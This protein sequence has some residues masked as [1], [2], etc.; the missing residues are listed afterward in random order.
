MLSA[1]EPNPSVDLCIQQQELGSGI[2]ALLIY[3]LTLL[4]FPKH[5]TAQRPPRHQAAHQGDVLS[6]ITTTSCSA[7][8]IVATVALFQQCH[9]VDILH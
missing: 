3:F 1:P 4:C 7:S 5:E 6:P 9:R 2:H 8:S